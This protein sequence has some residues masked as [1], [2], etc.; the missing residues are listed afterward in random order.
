M[1]EHIRSLQWLYYKPIS[2]FKGFGI[3]QAFVILFYC[4]Q[5]VQRR[6]IRANKSD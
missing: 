5:L 3:K 2:E 6:K 4:V 1:N